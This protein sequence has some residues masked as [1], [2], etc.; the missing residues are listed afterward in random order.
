MSEIYTGIDLG[1]NS[2]KVVVVEKLNDKYNV[3]LL[4]NFS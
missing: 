4:L 1:T 2:I 3:L